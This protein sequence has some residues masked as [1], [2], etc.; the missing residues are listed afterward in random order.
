MK[1]LKLEIDEVHFH[2]CARVSN[3]I[4]HRINSKYF[5]GVGKHV[6]D[7]VDDGIRDAILEAMD[8]KNQ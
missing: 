2:C 1:A 3:R 5:R 6:Y 4:G 8:E 7:Q